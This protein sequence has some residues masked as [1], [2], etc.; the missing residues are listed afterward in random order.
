M[1]YKVIIDPGHGGED[2]GA[3]YQGRFEKEDNLNLAL[4]LGEILE[5]NGLEVVYT[6]TMDMYNTPVEKA[7]MGNNSGADFFIS[8]HRNANPTPNTYS[9]VETLIFDPSG[10]KLEMAEN[11]NSQLETV[12]YNNLGI[13]IRPNLAVLRRTNM[14]A[15]LVEVGFINTDADNELFDARFG[16]IATAIATGILDTLD[17]GALEEI[18]QYKVQTG[19][20][21]N[22]DSANNLADKLV[23]DG[24]LA[25]IT[26]VNGL[27][28]V[29]VGAYDNLQDAI[30][31]ENQLRSDG[32]ATFITT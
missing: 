1:A 8:L 23:A 7:M 15:L 16:D 3:T 2:F 17:M 21:D 6:R 18:P 25:Y 11:I 12:G 5:D 9:G 14:P 4:A 30:D 24:Y 19:S 13:N 28:K 26:E 10:I 29:M 32:Y 31:T 20:F 22:I 27:Y